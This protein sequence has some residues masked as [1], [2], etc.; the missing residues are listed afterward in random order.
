M[1]KF[2]IGLL[3]SFAFILM[4]LNSSI[5]GKILPPCQIEAN[6]AEG[7]SFTFSLTQSTP[8]IVIDPAT[9]IIT[10]SSKDV[11]IH[12]ISIQARDEYG[13]ESPE[14][15]FSLQINSYCGDNT[16]QT[17]NS[18]GQGGP[19]NNGHEDCDGQDG[20]AINPADSVGGV[21]SYACSGPCTEGSDCTGTCSYL[22]SANGGGWCGDGIVQDG[23]NGT[24]DWSE[25]CDPAETV[26]QYVSRTGDTSVLGD[27]ARWQAISLSCDMT[28]CRMGCVGDPLLAEGCYIDANND[29]YIGIGECQKGKNICLNNNLKCVDVYTAA[30]GSVKF[31]YCCSGQS[32]FLSCT[33]NNTGAC[34]TVPDIG[35]FSVVRAN[36]TDVVFSA[37]GGYYGSFLGI[38][39]NTGTTFYYYTCDYVCKQTGQVCIGVGLNNHETNACKSVVHDMGNNCE[40]SGNTAY[41]D[42][43]SYFSLAGASTASSL[44]GYTFAGYL[45]TCSDGSSLPPLSPNFHVGEA[46]CYCQ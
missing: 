33:G 4:S 23:T 6:D 5:A 28:S 37:A 1:I 19:T 27:D 40:N 25:E 44:V 7:N 34:A 30:G 15:T 41:D 35:P 46:A 18:E 22:D 17:P 9:G 20:V 10:G 13:A 3:A 8:G 21:K 36:A 11:G 12:N 32:D 42:C 39:Q 26:T 29:G 45:G 2:N 16:K 43:K 24:A 14:A 31:D 38:Y